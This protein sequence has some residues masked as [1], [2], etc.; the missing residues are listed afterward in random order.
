VSEATER[1]TWLERRRRSIGA[2]EVAAVLGV[3]PYASPWDI[4]ADKR[5]LVEPWQGND[6]TRAGQAYERA[7]L[8]VAEE[9]LGGLDRNVFIRHPELPLAATL[10][11]QVIASGDPVEAKTSGLVGPVNGYWG[12]ELTDQVPDQY[13]LQCHAQLLCTGAEV[14]HLFALLAG[15]GTVRYRI[16]RSDKLAEQIGNICADWWQ[17]HVVGGEEPSRDKASLDVVKRLRRVPAKVVDLGGD[18]EAIIEERARIKAAMT[19]YQKLVENYDREI[20]IALGD[21]EGGTL[22][23]GR[24][25]TYLEQ[26]RKGYTVEPGKYRVLRIKRAKQ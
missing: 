24:E 10:D 21:A 11:A 23:D 7:V 3:S 16:E 14:V 4:W 26:E 22:P 25:V 13:L 15:R 17:R 8:D 5:G 2:S 12:D 20:L 18:L 1:E 6:A 19:Q 9:Q